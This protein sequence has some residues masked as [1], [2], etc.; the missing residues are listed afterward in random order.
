[1]EGQKVKNGMKECL[2]CG[3]FTL[4]ENSL[5]DI[6]DVCNWEDDPS[7]L[8]HPDVDNWGPN[9]MSLNEARKAWAEG[10]PVL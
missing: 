9:K 7:A 8:K 4:D 3:N 2:V 6:C 10:K 5:F 1:M